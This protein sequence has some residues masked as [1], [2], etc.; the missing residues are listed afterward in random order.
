[1]SRAV[2]DWKVITSKDPFCAVN[3]P[4]DIIRHEA[5]VAVDKE[6]NDPNVADIWECIDEDSGERIASYW[7]T[8]KYADLNDFDYRGNSVSFEEA[9][10][11]AESIVLAAGLRIISNNVRVMK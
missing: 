3:L 9:R 1:M 7:V 2:Y 8:K 4:G 11:H 6:E 10:R 5:M